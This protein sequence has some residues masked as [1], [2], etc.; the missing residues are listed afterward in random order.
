MTAT[1]SERVVSF[2]NAFGDSDTCT[3]N[4]YGLASV[5]A[6]ALCGNA[7]MAVETAPVMATNAPTRFFMS[8]R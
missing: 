7:T 1:L 2:C 8:F 4:P 5:W 3:E 6:A